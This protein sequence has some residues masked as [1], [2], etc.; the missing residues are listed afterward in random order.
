M[1]KNKSHSY[2][3]FEIA[4]IGVSGKFPEAN[5]VKEFWNNIVEG[6]NSVLE[7]SNEELIEGGENKNNIEN[8]S[9]VRFGSF[10]EDK[11]YFDSTFFDYSPSEAE[12]M[13]PQ[14]RIFHE[15]CWHALED[16]GYANSQLSNQK[17][18]L[19]AG[20]SSGVN[21]AV[22]AFIKNGQKQ[23]MD[24]FNV[25]LL[26]SVSHL[27]TMIA[28]KL[29]LK[30]PVMFMQTAC[31]SS[32]SA[33]H[34]AS[35][36]LLLGECKMALAGGA[37]I[38]NFSK[39]GYLYQEGMIQ[40]K[41]GYCRPFDH[42]ASGTVFGEGAGVVVLK[43]L[44]DALDDN[45]H[46]YAVIKGSGLNNDGNNKIGYTAPS[47]SGQVEVITKA[48]RN[49]KISPSSVSYIEA[50]GTGTV[51]GD[52]IEVSA[53]KSAY[54]SSDF[55]AGSCALGS[56]K[57]N[58][59][60]ADTA[61][62][63]AGFLK[64]VMALKHRQIPPSINFEGLNPKIDLSASPFYV[65]TVLKDWDMGSVPLRAGISSLGIGGT[66]VHM[67]L[68]QAPVRVGSSDSRKYDLLTVSGKT[69]SALKGNL[70]NLRSHLVS[71]QG[72][73]LSDIGYTLNSCRDSFGY[74]YSLVGRDKASVISE[75]SSLSSSD[76]NRDKLGKSVPNL[77]FMFP[78]QGSQYAS[79]CLELYKHERL[80]RSELDRCFSYVASEFGKDLYAVIYG[81]E[82]DK[83]VMTAYTQV[84]LF[85]IE[86]SLAQ[87][88]MSWGLVPDAMIGHSLGEYVAAC[89]SGVFSLEDALRLVVKR[90]E[91]MGSMSSGSMLSVLLSPEELSSYLTSYP[92]L[93]LATINS[94]SSCVVSGDTSSIVSLEGD[95]SSSG[96]KSKLLSTSHAF[97]SSMMDGV[98]ESYSSLFSEIELGSVGIPFV[99]NLTGD[100]VG[101]EVLDA[102]YWVRHL[103]ESVLFSSG[104]SRLMV[105]DSVCFVEVGPG[106]SLGSFVGSNSSKGSGHKIVSLLKSKG[107]SQYSVLEGLG[108]L[109]SYGLAVDWSSYYGEEL[110]HKVSLPGYSFDKLSYP[111]DV[112]AYDLISSMISDPGLEREDEVEHWL[113]RPTWRLSNIVSRGDTDRISSVSTLLFMDEAGIG[114]D[115]SSFFRSSGISVIEVFA[116][117]GFS[118]EGEGRY[119]IDPFSKRDYKLLYDSLSDLGIRPGRLIHCWSIGS[120]DSL[121]VGVEDLKQLY[122]YSLLEVLRLSE[123][124][125]LE[126]QQ[127]CVLSSDLHGVLSS[128]SDVGG[129]YKSLLLGF[130][131]VLGQE[132]PS[133]STGH[134]NIELSDFSNSDFTGV[135]YRDIVSLS[136][137]SVVTY[138]QG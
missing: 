35:N 68:E 115:L 112:N 79:M 93:S 60:H 65:N 10:L 20:C 64:V 21:W 126:L 41:D 89:L 94:A 24:E 32:L 111:V 95:L 63:I 42:R 49:S 66:N 74:R 33:I 47:I 92:S 107:D 120:W 78:G 91:L 3:G 53:L 75:L 59:G 76:L 45:D 109:W 37:T 54:S 82:S 102:S 99:S 104:L 4:V 130:L 56:V 72:D 67:I 128:R 40:S 44:Q 46:I 87:L 81:L 131:K 117:S 34:Q 6:K 61:S 101:D 9:Y 86:Y 8:E 125:G 55:V 77:V 134:I 100:Y 132:Y 85:S 11:K 124:Q 73:S 26:S 84:C 119:R 48:I 69:L 1:K 43:R 38:N 31:S 96:I 2:T 118:I 29:N 90:G 19:F 57:G 123:A 136:T 52:P 97:H 108:K 129:V 121:L 105:D 30:G 39:R 113:Y 62:G 110:R 17:V 127:V 88:L 15:C 23:L 80:F 58:I 83:L 114:S 138:E 71:D 106:R 122:F 14:I 28:Y 25:Q 116:G 137:G 103:R 50:H 36:S 22:H 12:L 18:G 51:L 5:N 27:S 7:F 133:I 16:S 70:D 13:N 98:L 135:L